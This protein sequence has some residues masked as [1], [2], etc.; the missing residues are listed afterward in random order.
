LTLNS[1]V[2]RSGR[3]RQVVHPFWKSARGHYRHEAKKEGRTR[4]LVADSGRG[5]ASASRRGQ[6]GTPASL[7]SPR[8]VFG[9]GAPDG[10][11]HPPLDQFGPDDARSFSSFLAR[12][13]RGRPSGDAMR[14]SGRR[15]ACNPRRRWKDGRQE[16][17]ARQQHAVRSRISSR[18]LM[19]TF[20]IRRGRR[21]FGPS[22]ETTHRTT[23]PFSSSG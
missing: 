23:G 8:S 9:S 12:T 3:A 1:L 22:P 13:S 11:L 17:P 20:R 2:S 18:C 15:H 5:Y 16:G 6:V 4:P 7:V 21:V 19:L 10:Q 14:W